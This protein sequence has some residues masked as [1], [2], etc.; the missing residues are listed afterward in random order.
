MPHAAYIFLS[1]FLPLPV[2]V[3]FLLL[4]LFPSSSCLSFLPSPIFLSFLPLPVFLSF[5]HLS[6]FPSS[7]YLSFL[8][9]QQGGVQRRFP[10]GELQLEAGSLPGGAVNHHRDRYLCGRGRG[11]HRLPLQEPPL[12][13]PWLVKEIT[14]QTLG[15]CLGCSPGARLSGERL[16]GRSAAAAR[17]RR[18]SVY[19]NTLGAITRW[20]GLLSGD[21]GILSG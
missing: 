14:H 3:S 5:L 21:S 9:D 4:S 18:T 1:N 19:R 7:S 8:S 13:A 2:F 20:R 11:T 17:P 15:M 16:L 12:V 6:L 10:R